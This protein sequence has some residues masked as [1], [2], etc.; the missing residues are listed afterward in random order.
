MDSFRKRLKETAAGAIEQ[1]REE[2]AKLSGEIWRKPELGFE[3]RT[4][5]KLLT[6]FLES[7]GFCVERG[8]AGMETAFRASIGGGGHSTGDSGPNICVICEYDALPDIG[9]ACGHNLIAE[10][11]VAAALGLKA[12]LESVTLVREELDQ[13]PE[14][15]P[16]DSRDQSN[17]KFRVTI[18]GSPAEESE[19]G[20]AFLI[21][22][23]AFE[24]I[25]VAMM[26]H[27]APY[28]VLKPEFIAISKYD[29]TYTGT[30]SHAAAF[31][32]EGLNALDAAVTAYNN[33]SVLRQQ[34]EPSLCVNGIISNGGVKASIIP[35]KTEM[36][37]YLRA[38]TLAELDIL[39]C[40]VRA[41]FE[42]AAV[43]TGCELDMKLSESERTY[44]DLTSNQV[45]ADVFGKNWSEL[46]AEFQTALKESG[47]TDMGNVSHVVPSIHPM[48]LIGT[49]EVYHTKDF[50][51]VT[52]TPEAHRST[53]VAAKAMAFTCIDVATDPALLE[54]IKSQ[55]RKDCRKDQS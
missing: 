21:D 35:E 11:G 36:V 45:L 44:E 4:A 33:L 12:A 53:L 29:I 54:V 26:V 38:P 41:C 13:N 39:T 34:L 37:F 47:S 5:H 24:D 8:Y 17:L 6:D 10:A 42:A 30:A 9:H 55:F 14:L 40:R 52:N 1:R 2:L 51:G 43:A 15:C 27:P 19:G 7:K 31:P 32:W 46:G 16:S 3:E 18:L 49:G 22:R 28:S 23:G 20:K 48:Y 50:T 25:D